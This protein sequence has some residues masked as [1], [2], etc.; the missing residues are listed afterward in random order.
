M[1]TIPIIKFR[2]TTKNGD[3][4]F[5]GF[6]YTIG[7]E[8]V[9]WHNGSAIRVIPESVAQLVGFD[10]FGKEVYTGDILLNFVGE[11]FTATFNGV[12][13]NNSFLN[14]PVSELNLKE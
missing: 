2:G 10:K 1:T 9:I 12:F 11:E 4:F 5:G 14:I 8:P 6:N 7:G 13:Y 3:T